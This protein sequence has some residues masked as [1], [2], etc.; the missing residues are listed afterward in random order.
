[1]GAE[2]CGGDAEAQQ[3]DQVLSASR[4]G[5]EPANAVIAETRLARRVPRPGDPTTG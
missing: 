4:V 3:L 2:A 5:I 1:M